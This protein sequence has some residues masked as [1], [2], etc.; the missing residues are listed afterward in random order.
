MYISFRDTHLGVSPQ[1][2]HSLWI[3]TDTPPHTHDPTPTHPQHPLTPPHYPQ[4]THIHVAC[5]HAMHVYTKGFMMTS[6]NGNIF[7]VIGPLCGE[8]ISHR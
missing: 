7:R 2:I 8:L 4:Q 3:I 1:F 5:S 6:S